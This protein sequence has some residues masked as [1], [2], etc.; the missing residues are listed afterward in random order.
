VIT[1]HIVYTPQSINEREIVTTIT[2]CEGT[3][4]TMALAVAKSYENNWWMG[5]PF[6]YR[7]KNVTIV[8]AELV[9]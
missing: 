4:L 5:C 1:I 8:S 9:K 2:C 6:G 7:L 3:T